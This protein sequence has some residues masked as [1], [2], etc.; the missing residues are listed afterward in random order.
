L[1]IDFVDDSVLAYANSI[2]VFMSR[3]LA[4]AGRERIIMD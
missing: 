1:V 3:E 4:N 2:E